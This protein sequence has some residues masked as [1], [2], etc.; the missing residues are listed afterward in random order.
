[1]DALEQNLA[2]QRRVMMR[3][4]DAM[5]SEPF[6]AVKAYLDGRQEAVGQIAGGGSTDPQEIG[7]AMQALRGEVEG[8]A[9]QSDHIK[10][11]LDKTDLSDRQLVSMSVVG[12]R[13]MQQQ[14]TPAT[15]PA[16]PSAPT[17]TM[18]DIDGASAASDA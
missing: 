6:A 10:Q 9:R 12:P 18:D 8:M 14:P 2:E 13:A 1:M 15:P 11:V 16:T 7:R 4:L 5:R 17:I 3:M